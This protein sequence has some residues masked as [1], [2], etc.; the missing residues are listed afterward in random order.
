MATSVVVFLPLLL[1]NIPQMP[2]RIRL[3]SL[4]FAATLAACSSES[5]QA[6]PRGD[7]GREPLAAGQAA[8]RRTALGTPSKIPAAPVPGAVIEAIFQDRGDGSSS[9][10]VGNGSRATFW[11]GYAYQVD[12]RRQYTGFVEQ[13]PDHFGSD[14]AADDPP[15]AKA[16]L[17]QATFVID[18]ARAGWSFVGAQRSIGEVGGRGQADAIDPS[19][20]PVMH[21]VS[22]TRLL[23]AVP[24]VAAIEQGTVQ[25]NY[26]LLLRGDKGAWL[27]IGT[28]NAGY[29]DRAGCDGGRAFPCTSM[30]GRLT[31]ERGTG[32]MP[33]I[34]IAL[35][36]NARDAPGAGMATY[37]FDP[38][39]SS[40]RTR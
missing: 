21:V 25:K 29:D 1:W 8:P 17:T 30:R 3:L 24:T 27:H 10:D 4:C 26:E 22:P 34:R 33:S 39:T 12:G 15:S 40:Y 13:S 31:F 32:E 6:Q 5:M 38:T 35:E 23:L 20:Q 37:R 36:P 16:T 7:W 14:S 9:Y 11:F 2:I 19:R 18:N 28:V